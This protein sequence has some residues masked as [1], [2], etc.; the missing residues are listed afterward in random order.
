MTLT[1]EKEA[2]EVLEYL[3]ELTR[4]SLRWDIWHSPDLQAFSLWETPADSL[5]VQQ[6]SFL[7][8][9]KCPPIFGG[10]LE[11]VEA[12]TKPAGM[13]L[14]TELLSELHIALHVCN[15]YISSPYHSTNGLG[16]MMLCQVSTTHVRKTKDVMVSA[17][18][19]YPKSPYRCYWLLYTYTHSNILYYFVICVYMY[20]IIFWQTI[21]SALRYQEKC[22]RIDSVCTIKFLK[23]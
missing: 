6:N 16:A 5:E 3:W 11:R 23:F 10:G 2:L 14:H 21:Q 20:V 19:F 4:I 22:I 12:S 1:R 9:K 13:F 7:E 18:I 15:P 17:Y 8:R